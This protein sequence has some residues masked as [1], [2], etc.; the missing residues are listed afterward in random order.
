MWHSVH[1]PLSTE[2]TKTL[3]WEQIHLNM[4]TTYSYNKWH[5]SSAE[6]P[7]CSQIPQSEFHNILECETVHNMWRQIEPHLIEIHPIP[8]TPFEM[9]FG[10]PGKTR[11]EVLRNWLT[12]LLREIISL[13]ER[14]AYH[15]KKGNLNE[16]DIK[17][18]FNE[19]MKRQIL[20]YYIIYK[21]LGKEGYFQ[22]S[23]AIN[24]HIITWEENQWQV[25]TIFTC[26][27]N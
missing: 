21:H 6:C 5:K 17:L 13:Q 7:L 22:N 25:L 3:I 27:E 18:N 15:N 2:D 10:L 9:A 16:L 24:D 1:N 23:F 12:F 20:Q 26:G 19:E 8:V 4:Y 14:P 11:N